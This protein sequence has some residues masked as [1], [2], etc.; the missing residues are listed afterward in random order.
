MMR[1]LITAAISIILY[2]VLVTIHLLGTDVRKLNDMAWSSE[3]RSAANIINRK[4]MSDRRVN[5]LDIISYADY[6]CV[7]PRERDPLGVLRDRG[8]S[9]YNVDYSSFGFLGYFGWNSNSSY[10]SII[11]RDGSAV[12]VEMRLFDVNEYHGGCSREMTLKFDDGTKEVFT[13]EGKVE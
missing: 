9:K 2:E 11:Y 12:I 10:V 8:I 5:L 13:F 7:T 6:F 1:F 4:M 3:A